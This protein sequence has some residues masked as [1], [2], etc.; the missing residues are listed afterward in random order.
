MT[1]YRAQ[2]ALDSQ[3]EQL[4]HEA[5]KQRNPI[6]AALVADPNVSEELRRTIEDLV[7]DEIHARSARSRY[8]EMFWGR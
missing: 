5:D 7:E 4:W 1:D 8:F 3:A 2:A 6:T